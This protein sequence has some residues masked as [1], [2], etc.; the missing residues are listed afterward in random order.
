MRH[1]NDVGA[2][3]GLVGVKRGTDVNMATERNMLGLFSTSNTAVLIAGVG[4]MQMLIRNA[5]LGCE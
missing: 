4:N 5:N 3:R 2:V 1:Y